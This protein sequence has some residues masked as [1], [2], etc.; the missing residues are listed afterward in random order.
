MVYLKNYKNIVIILLFAANY[1]KRFPKLMKAKIEASE[2]NISRCSVQYFITV[3]RQNS[4]VK[5]R[6]VDDRIII[7]IAADPQ[8]E[9]P[10]SLRVFATNKSTLLRDCELS[11]SVLTAF[12]GVWLQNP[13]AAVTLPLLPLPAFRLPS[14]RVIEVYAMLKF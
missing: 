3:H 8:L 2:A 6:R 7:Q 11:L 13:L 12:A 1:L 5:I 14:W 10:K 4:I 9:M